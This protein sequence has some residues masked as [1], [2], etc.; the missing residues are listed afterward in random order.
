MRSRGSSIAGNPVLI[1][2]ATVLVVIVAMFLSYNANAGLPFVPTY[3][4]KVEAPSAAALVKGNEVRIGGARVGAVDTI[5]TRRREDGSSVAVI[6]M[7]L[8]RAVDPL[9][10]DSTIIIRPKSALGLKYVE[11]TRGTSDEGYA[12]GDTIPVSASKP[13]EVEFDE[14]VNMFDDDT[15]AAAQENLRGFGDAFAG[16]GSSL[17]TALGVLPALL[18]DIQPVARNLSDPD[19]GLKTFFNELGDTARIVAPAAETQADLFVNLDATF[20]ALNAVARPYIQDSIT[21]GRPALD[22]AI[23]SFPIQRPFLR[24]TE[25]L[26]A[27]LRPGVRALRTAAPDLASAFTVGT[28]TLTRAPALNRRLASL[29]EEL[30]RFAN[31]PVAPRGI[32]RTA[33]TLE[34]LKR[35]LDHLAPAQLTCNY[36]TLWFRNV[37]S[38]LSEGDSHGT[39][40][41][42]IIITTPQGPNNEGGPSSAPANGPTSDNYLHSNPYP[43][44]ASPGQVKEC[45]SGNE[46]W[47]RRAQGD[48]QR[49]RQAARRHG[50]RQVM[51]TARRRRTSRSPLTIGLIALA[52]IVVG[53]WLGFTKDIPFT[54][55]FRVKATFESANSLRPN[56][57]VR[58]AGVAVGKVKTVEPKEGTD[59]ALVTLELKE[60]ALPIHEDATAKIRPRIFLEGNFFIDLTP[61]TP[62][63]PKLADGDVI[64]VTRTATPVQLDQVLTSLQSDSRQ[65]LRDLLDGLAVGLNSKPSAADDRNADRSARGETAAESFNDA[66]KDSPAALKGG[67]QVNDALLGTEPDR[68][69]ARLLEGTAKTTGALIRNEGLLKDLITNFNGTMAAFA[70]ESSNLSAS[71]RLLAPTLENANAALASLNAAF[72]PTRAFAREI[73]PGV[74]ETAATIDASFPWV[75]QATKLMSPARA[76]R[77][78]PGPGAGHARPREADQRVA[79]AAAPDRPHLAVRAR[80]RAADR[81]PRDP[82]PVRHRDREL[83]GVLVDDGRPRRREPELRRQRLLRALPDRRRLAGRRARRRELPDRPADRRRGGAG[84]GRA[85]EVPRQ[86]PAVRLE[87]ALP[88]EQ[89]PRRQRVL[90]G[91]GAG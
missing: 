71:I 60:S 5:T 81:R 27:D 44:T 51:A 45:E 62:S 22:A 76:A 1:G 11:I 18:R 41:R 31:D 86:A 34:T 23:R 55:G 84:A 8:E 52:I 16:R 74:R 83:Q 46:P 48:R 58:I 40:Q 88:Q 73:L 29:L 43:N 91:Q 57:P 39:W 75:D 19:T 49:A 15:R 42:F 10:K 9:P 80:R 90:G 26:F 64:K 89:D 12:D 20:T 7:K 14:F 13:T 87:H 70:S 50:G 65:D 33:E 17:N 37:S 3:Q 59:Q 69:V 56:S 61:G 82:R 85:A 53:V 25:L 21:E 32:K 2:A 63:S 35:P 77:P 67:A 72:P 38:L 79:H 68:D 36:A 28:R 4:L 6:G 54:H 78:R 30:Q 47:L 24:N 66:Y